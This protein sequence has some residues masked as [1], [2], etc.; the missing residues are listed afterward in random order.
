MSQAFT[1][2]KAVQEV[3]E[4]YA[5][6]AISFAKDVF[7]I[8]LDW[9]DESIED[10]ERILDAMHQDAQRNSPTEDQIMGFAKG[11]GSY[12]G[13]VFRRNHG[14]KWGLVH[15]GEDTF[16]GLQADNSSGLF[17]PWGKARN[18]IVNGEEDNVLQYYEILVREHSKNPFGGSTSGG[19]KKSFWSRLRGA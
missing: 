1:E 6:N 12:I 10:I 8:K 11:L 3:A 5:A 9:S 17:W 15:F 7:K 4:V 19:A 13:E 14:A 16:P 2:D 18:R